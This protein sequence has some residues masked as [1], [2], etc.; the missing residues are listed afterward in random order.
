MWP[1]RRRPYV[2]LEQLPSNKPEDVARLSPHD[3]CRYIAG[4][5]EGTENH[6]VGMMV[7]R[8]RERSLSG[9]AFAVSVLSLAVSIVALFVK[10]S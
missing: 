6:H 3:L 5:R 10:G 2:P 7:L 8:R 1:F 4:W 9:W